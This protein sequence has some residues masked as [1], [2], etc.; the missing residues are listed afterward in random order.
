MISVLHADAYCGFS[1]WVSDHDAVHATG[2]QPVFVGRVLWPGASEPEDTVIKLYPTD[3]CGVANEVIGFTANAVRG[4]DQPARGGVIL[5][6]REM[7]PVFD[8]DVTAY[9]DR[10]TGL[11]VC[12]AATLVQNAKPFRFL[13]RLSTFDQDQLAAF[14]RSKF[15]HIL[16]GVDHAT[17]NSDRSDANFLYLDDMKYVAID[18]GA[19]GGG[20]YWHSSWPDETAGNQ[21]N[22]AAQR[23][24]TASQL[25]SWYASVLQEGLKT[26]DIWPEVSNQL[27]RDLIGLLDSE[28]IDTIVEYMSTRASNG[29]LAQA[30]G[31]LI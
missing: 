17:G 18:Q 28:Q 25:S 29:T 10:S 9:V 11:A 31:R 6:N 12:W 2:A 19:V 5:L 4:V 20:P 16:T 7:L 24:M 14:F 30:C 13:R 26:Q 8:A 22:L 27:R 1:G 21:L 3:S 23:E 15:A